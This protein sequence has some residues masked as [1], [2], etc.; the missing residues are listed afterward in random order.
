MYFVFDKI[1]NYKNKNEKSFTN[2]LFQKF[3]TNSDFSTF[4]TNYT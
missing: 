4:D 3:F 2:S 1:I